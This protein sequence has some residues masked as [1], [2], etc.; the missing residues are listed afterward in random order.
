MRKRLIVLIAFVA[1]I[2]LGVVGGAYAY[3]HSKRGRIAEGVTVNGVA[4]GG[5]TRAQAEAK[6]KQTLLAPLDRPVKARFHNHVFTLTPQQAAIGID[7]GGTVD[8]AMARSQQSNMCSRSWRNL[9]SEKLEAQLAANVSY[10]QPAIDKL[11]Q[12]ARE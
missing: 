11:V 4:I 2:A 1:L 9:R 10:S 12:R 3:D 7:I 8:K 6:L 5:M